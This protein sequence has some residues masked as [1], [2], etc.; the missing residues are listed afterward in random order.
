M[1]GNGLILQK[2]SAL[3]YQQNRLALGTHRFHVAFLDFALFYGGNKTSFAYVLRL[4]DYLARESSKTLP[5]TNKTKLFTC[6]KSTISCRK[7][8]HYFY[9]ELC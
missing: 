2:T 9:V 6:R 7:C 3:P 8:G 1:R 4:K 5:T